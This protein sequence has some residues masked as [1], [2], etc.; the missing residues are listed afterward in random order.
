MNNSPV[1][2]IAEQDAVLGSPGRAGE[3]GG[4]EALPGRGRPAARRLRA[5]RPVHRA[6]RA[7]VLRIRPRPFAHPAHGPR[8]HV[9]VLVIQVGPSL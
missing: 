8:F 7:L 4:A 2:P 1:G 6:R 5:L 9:S 3:R